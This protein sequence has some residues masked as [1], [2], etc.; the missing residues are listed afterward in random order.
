MAGLTN[1]RI[2]TLRAK[3][4]MDELY[5]EIC[6]FLANEPIS[7][8]VKDDL[9]KGL[10]ITRFEVKIT[11]N[12]IPL[13]IGEIAY[14]LRSGL[15]QLAWQLALLSGRIPRNKTAF[16]IHKDRTEGSE[17]RF[18]CATKDIPREAV[19][20]IKTL[21]PY[22]RGNGFIK[23]PLWKLNLIC[24]LDKHATM[25][26]RSTELTVNA[27][28]LANDFPAERV[29]RIDL[30]NGMELRVPIAGK[31][32]VRFEPRPPE[33]IFGRP[34]NELGAPLCFMYSDITEIYEFVSNRVIP[35]FQ[36]FFP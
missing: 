22:N 19:E 12:N 14:N 20:T 13:L 5:H 28:I 24:N 4:H 10:H 11:P 2:K 8:T 29:E 15:D 6:L 25:P 34:S 17:Q 30:D 7:I 33:L 21:Q 35:Q 31:F 18:R 27:R 1:T 36:R 26:V 3:E 16:P 9:E 23:H 32:K